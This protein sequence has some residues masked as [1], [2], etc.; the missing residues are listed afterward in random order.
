MTAP[1]PRWL[2]WTHDRDIDGQPAY[3]VF[4]PAHL[5]DVRSR[6]RRTIAAGVGLAIF[7][8]A[9]TA[10]L[11]GLA[12]GLTV[13]VVLAAAAA[14][15][16]TDSTYG[17]ATVRITWTPLLDDLDLA[18]RRAPHLLPELHTLAWDT[19]TGRRPNVAATVEHQGA[20]SAVRSRL[21][22]EVARQ[23]ESVVDGLMR[24]A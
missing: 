9:V 20:L 7:A 3:L 6:R 15:L 4:A 18:R 5:A 14:V 2:V 10:V 13:G 17:R 22:N 23:G 19:L 24:A 1:A 8:A 16:T 11:L 12:V 21:R